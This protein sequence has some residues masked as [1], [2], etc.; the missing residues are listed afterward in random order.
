M[1][2]ALIT[3]ALVC[4]TVLRESRC[5]KATRRKWRIRLGFLLSAGLVVGVTVLAIYMT[6]ELVMAKPYVGAF[7]FPN[8]TP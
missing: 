7:S 3:T 8:R 5:L 4:A 1:N 6:V 2:V